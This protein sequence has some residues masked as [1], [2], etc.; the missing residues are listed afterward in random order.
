MH[1]CNSSSGEA[2][3]GRHWA[4]HSIPHILMYFWGRGW[5]RPLTTFISSDSRKRCKPASQIWGPENPGKPGVVT[6]APSILVL[7]SQIGALRNSLISLL[8]KLVSSS[9]VRDSFQNYK[10]KSRWGCYGTVTS[11]LHVHLCAHTHTPLHT[12]LLPKN[13]NL[14]ENRS[15]FSIWNRIKQQRNLRVGLSV[16][17]LKMKTQSQQEKLISRLDKIHNVKTLSSIKGPG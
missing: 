14:I 11:G 7:K 8:T 3:T 12:T 2:S 17:N 4:N 15:Y 16:I 6:Q 9:L 10:V 5:N 13:P 1:S